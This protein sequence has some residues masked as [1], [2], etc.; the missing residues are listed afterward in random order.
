MSDLAAIARV[1]DGLEGLG[2]E[3]TMDGLVE[4][5]DV[6]ALLRIIEATAT[7]NAHLT[8]ERDEARTL[9]IAERQDHGKFISDTEQKIQEVIDRGSSALAQR[10]LAW[11]ALAKADGLMRDAQGFLGK[12]LD[13]LPEDT[14]AL[15]GRLDKGVIATRQARA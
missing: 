4:V 15:I 2:D 11:N 5:P 3:Y 7:D 12:Y 13:R 10:D 6:R 1:R 9:C 8:E 14:R